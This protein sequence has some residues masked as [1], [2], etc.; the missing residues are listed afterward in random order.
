MRRLPIILGIF[1]AAACDGG[2]HGGNGG[3]SPRCGDNE[4]CVE[5]AC[6]C[7]PGATR[8]ASG[9]CVI[10]TCTQCGDPTSWYYRLPSP[11]DAVLWTAPVIEKVLEG[12][13]V[14]E[15]AGESIAVSAARREFEPFQV[16]VNAA[17]DMDVSLGWEGPPAGV[18]ARAELYRVD[19]VSVDSPSDPS[20]MTGNIP[21]PL[22]PVAW[23]QASA[24]RAGRNQAFWVSLLVDPAAP[25]GDA[26]AFLTVTTPAGASRIP[27]ALH[28]FDFTLPAAISLDAMMNTSFQALGGSEGLEKV[29]ELKTFFFEHRLTPTGVAW[30]AG[31]NYNGGIE[32][33]CAGVIDDEDGAYG[34]AQLGP[35]YIDGAGWNGVGF[36]SFE[37]FQFTDN[38]TPRPDEFCGVSRG[39][40]YGT[41]AY[42]EAWS[43][44]LSTVNGYVVDRGWT[45][46]AYY[47]VMNEPQDQE[48]Y[49][50]AA[51]LADLTSRAAPDLRIAVSE[52]PKPEIAEHPSYASP[53]YDIWIAD[54]SAY[55]KDYAWQ[56]Q[57]G[58]GE[59]V[60]WYFLYGDGPP[61]PNPLTIDH[62]GIE[63][64]II[65]WLA[66]TYRVDGLAYYSLTGWGDDPWENP[67]PQ[68]TN[69]NGDG[70]MLYPPMEDGRLRTSIR[71]ELLR[72][73]YEDYEYFVL[74]AGGRPG[75][76][77]PAS[78]DVTVGSA[79]SS[80]T[81]WL[82]DP[83][84]FMEL[85]RQLGRYIGGEIDDLPVVDVGEGPRP[86]GA[87]SINF[88]D[89][90]G[91]PTASP[92]VVD[93]HEYMK[94]G[95]NPYDPA[96][97]Y[98][99]YGENLGTDRVMTAWIDA[100]VDER[101]RSIIYDDWGRENTFEFDIGSGA[102]SVTVSVGWYGRTYS[103]HRV[104]VEGVDFI[105]DGETT[106]DNPYI[107]VTLPVEIGDGKLT[108]ETG[109]FDEYTMLN[110]M[111][112]EPAE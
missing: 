48:D 42:N 87:Y 38:S 102:Y 96:L 9:R 109:I 56:R 88:Q 35:R 108:M 54:L 70:F 34:F 98:G 11:E 31:L 68:G 51:Y 13:Q 92:L 36:P 46:K 15:N 77:E 93:G 72:E 21:D 86:R 14:P 29:E 79:A 81:G 69:Q 6:Q 90:A 89:P 91:D 39:D 47:Y 16:V 65:T 62:P 50:L 26:E 41:A 94:I 112:I 49:D 30:P 99:W 10:P 57:Q 22:E 7:I 101:Q 27:V 66:W 63:S 40:A 106:P 82:K 12:Q 28:V 59:K 33:D 95:W 2:G 53:S 17:S 58:N 55:G 83:A 37:A 103:H 110:Y 107:V 104:V 18:V 100:P 61:Y 8:D 32:Y 4:T 45:G 44:L 52:E 25:A 60:W 84:A 64:R 67:R 97:A 71:F 3:C 1:L 76:G 105:A 111:D 19:R 78:V 80:L 73:A 23:G 5:G 24:V 85:R 75:A 20:G 74:A 43:L